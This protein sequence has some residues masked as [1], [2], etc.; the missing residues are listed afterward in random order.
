[1]RLMARIALIVAA[2]LCVPLTVSGQAPRP[3]IKVGLLLP[4]TGVIAINGQETSKGV[5]FY[6]AKIGNKAGG[7]E[8]QL[9]KEDD[10]AKPDVGLTKTRKLVERDRVDV[11]IGPVHSGVALAIRDYVHGQGIPLIVPVAFTRDLTAPSKASPWLF[12]VVET[13]DQGNFAMGGWVFKKT[14]YRK[15]V[16]M[17]SDFVAGRHSAEAFI[18]AFKAA[19]GEIVKEIYAPLNT[20]DFAPYMA[21]VSGLPA[22]AVYAWFGGT[23]SVRFVKAY[24]EYGLGGKLPLLGYN[25]LVDDVLLPA[26][27]DAALGIIS[28]GHYSAT[29]DTPE[30]RAFVREHEAR[31]NAW[32]TRYVELG[33]VSGQLVGAAIEALKGEVGDRAAFRDAIR[34]AATKIQPPRGP[35]RFDRYQQVITDVYVMKVERQGNR[36]VNAIV[37]RIPNTSQEESWKWWN[38]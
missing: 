18:A 5:E 30:N 21:Q 23:D 16:V 22:D 14:P 9:L 3:P 25:T 7:R 1:M 37:D 6:F 33:Y 28:V 13:S 32:P 27:G 11:L 2:L 8:I 26:L 36:L 35:I 34:S 31:Y 24:R 4:Y 20:P 17:A 12:R 15:I 38:K 29:L 19:G 10:E